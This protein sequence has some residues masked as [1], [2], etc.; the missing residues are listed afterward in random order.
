MNLRSWGK[1]RPRWREAIGYVEDGMKRKGGIIR[2]TGY[3]AYDRTLIVASYNLQ[4]VDLSRL[5]THKLDRVDKAC[6]I[7]FSNYLQSLN[8]FPAQ[9]LEPLESSAVQQEPTHT[10]HLR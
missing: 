10:V 7:D 2:L 1:Y 4:T 3:M 6:H 9:V 8:F 5:V